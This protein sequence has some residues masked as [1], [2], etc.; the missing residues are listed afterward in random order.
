MS[1]E[2]LLYLGGGIILLL[3]LLYCVIAGK[4]K[5]QSPS[6]LLYKC[7]EYL[8]LKIKCFLLNI[9]AKFVVSAVRARTRPPILNL[10]EG[11]SPQMGM[12][13]WTAGADPDSKDRNKATEDLPPSYDSL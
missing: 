10:P 2:Y 3:I 7:K 12:T 4:L 5:T 13:V 11:S 9:K 6:D 8:P 1:S